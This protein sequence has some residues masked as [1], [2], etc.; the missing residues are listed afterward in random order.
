MFQTSRTPGL[1]DYLTG[2]ATPRDIVQN[3]SAP[4]LDFIARGTHTESALSL[5]GGDRL[6]NLLRDLSSI[7]EVIIID[8]PPFAAGADAYQFDVATRNLVIVVRSGQTDRMLTEAKLST[9]DRL[10]VRVLG[11][12]LN[13]WKNPLS[14]TSTAPEN[15]STSR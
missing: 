8:S 15:G 3:T 7:Y 13:G 14:R 2:H 5:L 4:L 10:P 12:V 11:A 1:T 6:Q 9:L